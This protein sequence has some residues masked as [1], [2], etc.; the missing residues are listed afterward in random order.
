LKNGKTEYELENSLKAT[1]GDRKEFAAEIETKPK[2][3]SG[4]GSSGPAKTRNY[5]KKIGN[6]HLHRSAMPTG[7]RGR[8]CSI[9]PSEDFQKVNRKEEEEKSPKR[10][11]LLEKG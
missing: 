5:K 10:G 11:T 8:G 1:I 6:T 4:A 7:G 2:S 3:C 9:E